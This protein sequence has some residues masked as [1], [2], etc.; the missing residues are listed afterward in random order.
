MA[1]AR[2]AG[3]P[4]TEVERNAEII[5]AAVN[6]CFA[7]SPLNPLAVA[8]ALPELVEAC[9]ESLA[10]LHDP[11]SWEKAH[12]PQGEFLPNMLEAAL[13]KLKGD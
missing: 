11:N 4:W 3:G 6:A 10:F 9:K 5:I 13:A 1:E 8:E 7:V 12:N 2:G